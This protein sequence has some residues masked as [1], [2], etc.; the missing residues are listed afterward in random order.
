MIRNLILPLVIPLGI[1]AARRS[2]AYRV[3]RDPLTCAA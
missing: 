1:S 3:E 2:Y